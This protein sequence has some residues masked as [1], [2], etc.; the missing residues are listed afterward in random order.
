MRILLALIIAVA[1]SSATAALTVGPPPHAGPIVA[2][3]FYAGP[4]L[5]GLPVY[6]EQWRCWGGYRWMPLAGATCRDLIFHGHPPE[7]VPAHQ[8]RME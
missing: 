6:V 5:D 7:P 2:R 1:P 3:F 4:V 8:R